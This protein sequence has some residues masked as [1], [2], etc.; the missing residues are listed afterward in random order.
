MLEMLTMALTLSVPVLPVVALLALAEWRD[1]RQAALV[2]RQ[3][4]L[5]DAISAELGSVVAPVV[6]RRLRGPWQVEMTVPLRRPALVGKVL[7]ITHRVLP[8]PCEL[9]LTPRAEPVDSQGRPDAPI[10]RRRAGTTRPES[11]TNFVVLG[12]AGLVRAETIP[13]HRGEADPVWPITHDPDPT[14]SCVTR[15]EHRI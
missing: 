4:R 11:T 6:K 14:G 8:R 5:T 10:R 2:A 15:G 9:R 3:I 12:R 7:E 1:R 13:L